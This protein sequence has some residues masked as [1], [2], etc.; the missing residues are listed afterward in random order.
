ML[1]IIGKYNAKNQSI[2]NVD[3]ARLLVNLHQINDRSLYDGCGSVW[4]QELIYQILKEMLVLLS[5]SYFPEYTDII[6]HYQEWLFQISDLQG[7][8]ANSGYK[9]RYDDLHEQHTHKVIKFSWM[10]NAAILHLQ[11]F[12]Q[13]ATSGKFRKVWIFIF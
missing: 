3:L 2:Q 6:P 10:L 12:P 11:P 4:L 13:I 5:N 7:E 1:L 9:S 8:S